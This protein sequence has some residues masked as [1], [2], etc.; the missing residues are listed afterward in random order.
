MPNVI[1]KVTPKF[2]FKKSSSG[3]YINIIDEYDNNIGS[4][5][6][7]PT[8]NCQVMAFRS[9]D[10]FYDALNE[11]NTSL[12]ECISLLKYSGMHKNQ[13]LFDVNLDDFNYN[14]FERVFGQECVVFKQDYISTNTSKMYMILIN[15][16]K[17]KV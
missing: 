2:R 11:S 9:F 4:I 12:K 6:Y 5:A 10:E 16:L 3:E 1:A 15:L 14:F 13:L 8:N 7:S 17:V